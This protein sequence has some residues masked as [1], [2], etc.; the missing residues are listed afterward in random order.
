L[1]LADVLSR[2]LQRGCPLVA[3]LGG[4]SFDMAASG[5]YRGRRVDNV[6]FQ[7]YMLAYLGSGDRALI[8]RFSRGDGSSGAT[9]DT[10]EAWPIVAQSGRF[11]VRAPQT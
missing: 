1:I 9:A 5:G 3:D 6:A 10:I 8:A 4:V 7:Q 2:N 11:A